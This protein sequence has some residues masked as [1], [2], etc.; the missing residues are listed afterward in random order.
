MKKIF[1]LSILILLLVAL[2]SVDG[3]AQYGYKKKKKKKKRKEK[4]EQVDFTKNLWYGGGMQI[5][6]GSNQFYSQFIF[7][8]SPMVGYKITDR[9]SVG[10]RISAT[11][12]NFRIQTFTGVE[13]R[14][15]VSWS[16]AAFTR[17]KILSM[18]FTHL[19]YEYQNEAFLDGNLNTAYDK[20]NNLFLGLGYTSSSG[21]PIGY[22]FLL[23]YNFLIPENSITNPFDFRV[24]LTY[25]F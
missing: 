8:L 13:K 17:Y 10:P 25:N 21:G 4:T 3:N 24:A 18:L 14:T 15:P 16:V 9:L 22:E 7:G 12:Y 2:I 11:L 19:E 20:N 23:L 5:N 1:N 6:F